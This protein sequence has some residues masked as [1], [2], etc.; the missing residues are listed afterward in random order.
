[1]PES[2]EKV[3]REF[4]DRGLIW[5][6]ESPKNLEHFVR[7]FAAEL[8]ERLDFT[9]AE[10]IPRTFISSGLEKTETDILF[11]LP[12]RSAD[13]EVLIYILNELQSAPDNEMG[14]NIYSRRDEIW[15]REKRLWEELPSP[16][17]YFRLH[18]VVPIIFYTGEKHWNI[19]LGMETLINTPEGMSEFNPVWK[20][21]F[22]SLNSIPADKLMD[23]GT[24]LALALRGLQAVGSDLE[25]M[26]AVVA[27]I[28]SSLSQL[29][30]EAQ[31]EW[32]TAMRFLLLMVLHKR[33]PS[34]RDILFRVIDSVVDTKHRQEVQ[35]M[36]MTGADFLRE[37]GLEQGLRESILDIIDIRFKSIPETF[38]STLN[39]IQEL[40]TLRLLRKKA[41]EAET[42]LLFEKELPK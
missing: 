11:R 20:T 7:L 18:L 15:K 1:M 10:R 5:L 2:I 8:A 34:E 32:A 38:R 14:F 41:L 16:R 40:Q 17:P 31:S 12:A 25:Q 13:Q 42:L 37:E 27:Q 35:T 22:V 39:Q 33:A 3:V 23:A 19:P 26:K 24:G 28:V 21:L 9:R 36:I 4:N 6:L 30:A 29:P